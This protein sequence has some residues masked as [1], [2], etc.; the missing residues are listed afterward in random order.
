MNDD[1]FESLR[2]KVEDT[3]IREQQEAHHFWD[4]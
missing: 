2:K 4:K 1:E 3:L